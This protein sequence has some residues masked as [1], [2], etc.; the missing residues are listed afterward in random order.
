MKTSNLAAAAA[1]QILI[2]GYF[3]AVGCAITNEPD[4]RKWSEK[5]RFLWVGFSAVL[6]TVASIGYLKND[7]DGRQR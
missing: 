6:G 2:F 1:L 7:N 5:S 4:A 3:W